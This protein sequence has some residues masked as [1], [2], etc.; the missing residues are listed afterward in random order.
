MDIERVYVLSKVKQQIDELRANGEIVWSFS[1]LGSFHNCEY[2]YYNT[3]VKKNKTK[4][5]CYGAIGGSVHDYIEGIYKG[6]KDIEGFKHAFN[7][8]IIEIELLDIDFPNELIKN[9]F[10][11]DV[12][13]FAENFNKLEGKFLLEHQ[14][15]FK[16]GEHWIQGFIDVI[17]VT[18]DK[19][20]NIID[21]K[22]SSKFTGDKLNDSGRQLLM[23]KWALES[24]TK[25]K[26]NKVM[27]C[28]IKYIYVCHTQKNGKIKRKMVNRGKLIKEMRNVFEK[29]MLTSGMDSFEINILL[30]ECAKTNTFDKLPSVITD[31]YWLEDCF[32]EYEAT[33]EK[34]QELI[35]YVNN[36]IDNINSKDFDNAD[37]W[38]PAISEK[39]SFYCN[40]LCGHRHTC[41]FRKEFIEKNNH[42]K[43][44]GN[45]GF[46]MF[47]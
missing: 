41:S 20:L 10:V 25:H 46:N 14:V 31:K 8:S 43:K 17:H 7:Q 29:E 24:T 19:E 12:K 1:R 47:Y 6:E 40:T 9:S 26:I 32:V 34:I 33:E 30:D 2:E 36:T 22:T 39:N 5:N 37:D 16:V 44:N 27:W 42:K 38:K 15:L 28:M 21:W 4:Q 35:T 3:Y 23:Y 13:H 18:E 45:D 11:S